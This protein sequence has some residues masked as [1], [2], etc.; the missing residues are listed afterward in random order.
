MS[1][2]ALRVAGEAGQRALGRIAAGDAG[3][4]AD[5][6][7]HVAAVR[8][9]LADCATVPGGPVAAAT[10][11]GTADA[12]VGAADCGGLSGLLI[13]LMGSCPDVPFTAAAR[14]R[15]A[16]PPLALLLRYVCGFIEE[17]VSQGIGGLRLTRRPRP[18]GSPCA[19]RPPCQLIS[20]AEQAA[21][22]R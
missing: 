3:G 11:R 13:T 5:F 16:I 17:A 18:T 6:D 8:D 22:L 1:A 10:A 4:R 2:V 7:Q 15:E 9:A 21:E 12:R 14:D 20:Q 19:S